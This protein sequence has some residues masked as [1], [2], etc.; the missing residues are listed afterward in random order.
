MTDPSPSMM[1]SRA[2]SDQ[3]IQRIRAQGPIA[4]SAFMEA[5]LYTPELG[6]Y[7]Q[8]DL[9][10]GADFITSPQLGPWLAQC[11]AEACLP[12][13]QQ[14]GTDSC[15]VEFGPGSGQLCHDVL[16]ACAA[17][18]VVPARYYMIEI[19]PSLRAL[20]ARTCETLPPDLKDRI[21][22]VSACPPCSG[23]VIANE[24]LDAWPIEQFSIMPDIHTRCVGVSD[25]GELSWQLQLTDP[26]E[27]L[28]QA[29]SSLKLNRPQGFYS[30]IQLNTRA[31]FDQLYQSLSQGAVILLDYG[32]P[33]G[34]YYSETRGQGT[35]RCHTQHRVHDDPLC[36][37][38]LQD[39]T[40]QVNWTAVA[41]DA[42]DVGWQM[43]GYS[44]QAQFLLNNGLADRLKS[45]EHELTLE[46]CLAIKQLTL[47]T[48]MGEAFK[49]L[50]LSKGCDAHWFAQHDRQ[51]SLW[52]KMEADEWHVM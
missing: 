49:V 34:A 8:P 48:E 52:H 44:A 45:L 3:I 50:G 7:M 41:R 51:L 28:Y 6:Y 27:P 16:S 33:E 36:G 17:A 47:P 9:T 32:M 18:G 31:W 15:L 1:R 5:A 22:W 20:Q 38:G 19:S 37:P 14:C 26:S 46:D 2:L 10:L 21:T 43:L 39:I 40:A 29:V 42:I 4:F 30:E 13:L 12:V 25:Q 24:F 11:L 23:V 35:V